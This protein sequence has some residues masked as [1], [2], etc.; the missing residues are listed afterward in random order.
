VSV[1]RG[2]FC[3]AVSVVGGAGHDPTPTFTALPTLD[4]LLGNENRASHMSQSFRGESV[5]TSV[6]VDA[7][8]NA[9]GVTLG[10]RDEEQGFELPARLFE[11]LPFAVYICD[12]NGLVLRYNRR[13][14][15]LWGRSPKLRDPDERFCGSYRMFRPDGTLLPHHQCPMADVLRTGV[16]VR[17][18]EVHIERPN[19]SRGIALVDIE[20]VKDSEGSIVGA[21]NCFQ[22][23]T[24]R[25]LAED[26]A[27]RLAAIVE[28]SDDAIVGKDLDGIIT[29]WNAGAARIFGYE[30]EEIIGKPITILVPLDYR[31]EEEAIIERIRHGRRVE[32]YETVRQRKHGSLIDVSLSVSPVKNAEGK[33]IGASKIARDITERKRSEAQIVNLAREAEHRTKNILATVLATVRLSYAD[34]SDDLKNLIEGRIDALAKVHALFVESRWTGAELYTLVTQE[35]SP[36]RDGRE[37]RV[38]INGPTIMLEPNTAQAIAIS[39]H[40]LATN[41]GKYGSLSAADGDVEVTWSPMADGRLGLRWTEA[42]GP[43][44]ATPTH[45][46][47]GTRV[48]ENII[49]QLG[50]QVLFD[51][52]DQGLRCEIALRL[53]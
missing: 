19:G 11:Q 4:N 15:E 14:A 36:Y 35:L 7:L 26:A 45:R 33:I 37:E 47:F 38:R 48:M 41:A 44:V 53:A 27:L 18:Q 50:G 43:T 9:V 46:G 8:A 31:K 6:E 51:W 20:A 52:H 25:K 22:D 34:T 40:E 17:Q 23:V 29:S 1:F 16:P 39:L 42:G 24:D 21:V 10:L 5:R 2:P 13:A 32:H 12:R 28:S 49:E 30:A 3:R